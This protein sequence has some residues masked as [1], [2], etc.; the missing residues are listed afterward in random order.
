MPTDED[1]FFNPMDK[2]YCLVNSS[3]GIIVSIFTA[4]NLSNFE[5]KKN[6]LGNYKLEKYIDGMNVGEKYLREFSIVNPTDLTVVATFKA[7]EMVTVDGENN[8]IIT[9]SDD[10]IVSDKK[11]NS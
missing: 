1:D 2:T 3:T 11:S 9:L 6:N 4:C 5:P 8:F 10:T 7:F